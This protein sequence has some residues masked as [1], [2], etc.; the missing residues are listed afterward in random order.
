MQLLIILFSPTMYHFFLSSPPAY[1]AHW[2]QTSLIYVTVK[3]HTDM[4]LQEKTM[5][6]YILMCVI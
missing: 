2:S 6:L 5:V 3:F 1:C 4:K